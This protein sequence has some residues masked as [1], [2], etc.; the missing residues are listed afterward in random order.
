MVCILHSMLMHIS[1]DPSVKLLNN[2]NIFGIEIHIRVISLKGY[3]PTK[4]FSHKQQQQHVKKYTTRVRVCYTP[5]ILNQ[6]LIDSER[7]EKHT[8]KFGSSKIIVWGVHNPVTF[9]LAPGHLR[10]SLMSKITQWNYLFLNAIQQLK[11]Y[12]KLCI[13]K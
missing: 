4:H 7:R 6:I 5:F 12:I 3:S 2:L 9:L 8:T 1:L 11:S 13:Q 10:M